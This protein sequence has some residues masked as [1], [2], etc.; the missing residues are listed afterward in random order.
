MTNVHIRSSLPGRTHPALCGSVAP[1]SCCRSRTQLDSRHRLL[2]YFGSTSLTCF[3]VLGRCALRARR[4]EHT[5][6]RPPSLLVRRALPAPNYF[7][8]WFF[9]NDPPTVFMAFH[10]RMQPRKK[11]WWRRVGFRYRH[12]LKTYIRN[13]RPS[14]EGNVNLYDS[15]ALN[16][17]NIPRGPHPFLALSLSS[18][19]SSVLARWV[20]KHLRTMNLLYTYKLKA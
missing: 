19:L 14:S 16:L 1:Q 12:T 8:F 11:R 5:N 13:S 10:R 3:S 7:Q 15:P 17:A 4:A 6:T 18:V 20:Y 2:S 9:G